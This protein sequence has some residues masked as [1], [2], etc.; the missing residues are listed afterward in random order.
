[1][2]RETQ[3]T[4]CD[5]RRNYTVRLSWERFCFGNLHAAV[6][7]GNMWLRGSLLVAAL[8]LG[9]AAGWMVGKRIQLQLPGAV[10]ATCVLVSGSLG[11]P[12]FTYWLFG[13]GLGSFALALLLAGFATG[14]VFWSMGEQQGR[15]RLL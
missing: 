10:V 11:G 8:L 7:N 13:R 3:F 6:K 12:V 4:V 5:W 1:V 2:K 15:R 9:A 14:L